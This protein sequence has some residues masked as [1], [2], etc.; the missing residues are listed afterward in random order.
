MIE[1]RGGSAKPKSVVERM[2]ETGSGDS[3]AVLS[4]ESP[5]RR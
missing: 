4:R 1:M 2:L 3:G 5:Y